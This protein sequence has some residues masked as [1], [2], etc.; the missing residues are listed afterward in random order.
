MK[1]AE[2]PPQNVSAG[3]RPIV[4]PALRAS[5]MTASTSPRERVQYAGVTPPQPPESVTVL[6]SASFPRSQSCHDHADALEED[7]I[8]GGGRSRPPAQRLVEGPGS[9]EITHSEGHQA[10]PLLHHFLLRSLWRAKLAGD[11]FAAL[12]ISDVR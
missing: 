5:S 12:N 9:L 7:D 11:R 6:S 1:I 3:S 2:Y 10:H 8:V 4:A